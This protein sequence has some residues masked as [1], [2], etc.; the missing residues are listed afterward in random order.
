MYSYNF[1][2]TIR[3]TYEKVCIKFSSILTWP[4]IKYQSK[5]LVKF[6]IEQIFHLFVD[7]ACLVMNLSIS[8][9]ANEESIKHCECVLK[10][11]PLIEFE[12]SK[13]R[14]IKCFQSS[15]FGQTSSLTLGF[16][17]RGCNSDATSIAQIISAAFNCLTGRF[18]ESNNLAKLK[19]TVLHTVN[20]LLLK[21][22]PS[23]SVDI[24]IMRSIIA[25]VSRCF[26]NKSIKFPLSVTFS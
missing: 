1:L 22:G 2:I 3:I 4:K 23:K 10:M 12:V 5:Q 19:I 9:F 26:N 15:Q 8:Q 21:G 11:W 14:P 25:D 24:F 18:L 17:S 7:Y 6:S 13:F 16:C 20:M